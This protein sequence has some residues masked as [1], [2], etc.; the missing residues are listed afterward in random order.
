MAHSLSPFSLYPLSPVRFLTLVLAALVFMPHAQAQTN[1]MPATTTDVQNHTAPHDPDAAVTTPDP[2]LG[3]PSS[4]T[5]TSAE[6][7]VQKTISQEGVHVVHFWAPWCGNSL[8]E[9]EQGWFEAIEDNPEVSFTFVTV[10]N[11]G[12]AGQDALDR[13]AIPAR[14]TVLTQPDHG[15]S[16]DKSNRRK[17]FLGLPVTWIPTTWVFHKEGQLAYAFNYGELSMPQLQ[18]AID[19]ARSTWSH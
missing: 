8:R 3:T 14:V 4:R 13:Y 2:V 5:L 12:E 9:L 11:D 16:E 18:Q 17:S 19:G 10:W 7:T 1:N 6:E 15:P